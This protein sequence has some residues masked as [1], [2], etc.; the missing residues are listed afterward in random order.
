MITKFGSFGFLL[1]RT[2]AGSESRIKIIENKFFEPASQLLLKFVSNSEGIVAGS[3]TLI[4]TGKLNFSCPVTYMIFYQL[5]TRSEETLN[6]KKEIVS[7]IWYCCQFQ[8][9]ST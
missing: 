6:L 8:N 7:A 3:K 4:F 1:L 9:M 2:K 5:G